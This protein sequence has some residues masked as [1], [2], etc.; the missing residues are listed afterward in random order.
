MC[1]KFYGYFIEEVDYEDLVNTLAY[2]LVNLGLAKWTYWNEGNNNIAV[3][4][5]IIADFDDLPEK[6]SPAIDNLDNTVFRIKKKIKSKYITPGIIDDEMK[7]AKYFYNDLALKDPE[8]RQYI[9]T[10]EEATIS[11]EVID[12]ITNSIKTDRDAMIAEA[13]INYPL[14]TFQGIDTDLRYASIMQNLSSNFHTSTK[15]VVKH[16]ELKL[17][18]IVPKP[19]QS[20]FVEYLKETYSKEQCEK[21]KYFKNKSRFNAKQASLVLKGKSDT[22]WSFNPH[23]MTTGRKDAMVDTLEELFK[24]GSGY[25]KI[26]E[27]G[28]QYEATDYDISTL[29]DFLNQGILKQIEK[30]Q[31]LDMSDLDEITKLFQEVIVE[32]SNPKESIQ[33]YFETFHERL[34]KKVSDPKLVESKWRRILNWIVSETVKDSS[35]MIRWVEYKENDIPVQVLD[36]IKIIDIDTKLCTKLPEYQKE[37]YNFFVKYAEYLFSADI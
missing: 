33:N 28:C 4:F 36:S 5:K 17:G 2:E 15:G 9:C 26:F 16:I 12:Q 8:L 29:V 24:N 10:Y 30:Y 37:I 20:S 18:L 35:I 1:N 21:V 13:R 7:Y 6:F 31:S 23:I 3:I 34:N 19:I 25:A 27:N 22:F 14:K 11:N 32:D